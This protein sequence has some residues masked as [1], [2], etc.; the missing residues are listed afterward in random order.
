MN[1]VFASPKAYRVSRRNVVVGLQIA[2]GA[3]RE[4]VQILSVVPSVTLDKAP[5]HAL[6]LSMFGSESVPPRLRD[7]D[8]ADLYRCVA[9]RD[10]SSSHCRKPSEDEA[11]DHPP[12]EAVAVRKQLLGGAMRAAG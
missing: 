11:S 12:A 9:G 3:V 4:F 10:Y 7:H 6:S 1:I 8:L 5:A 2:S